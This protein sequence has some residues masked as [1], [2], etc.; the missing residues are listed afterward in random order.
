MRALKVHAFVLGLLAAGTLLATPAT[1]AATTD[2]CITAAI[3]EPIRLPDGSEHDAGS[4]TLCRRDD[5]TPARSTHETYV[6]RRPIGLFLGRPCVAE[7]GGEGQPFMLF[8]READ[9]RLR[10]Y[11]YALPTGDRTESFLLQP[12]ASRGSMR[13][14]GGQ[15]LLKA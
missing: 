12:P 14:S 9:G 15:C 4:L 2:V 8:H 1:V 11:G 7:G 13:P 3:D 6:D 5:F 10:L